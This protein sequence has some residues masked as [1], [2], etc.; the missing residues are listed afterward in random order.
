MDTETPNRFAP[1]MVRLVAAWLLIGAFFKLLVGTPNDLPQVV[2][3]LPMELGLTYSLVI[4]IELAL[5]FCALVKPA[6]A[7]FLLSGALVVFDVILTT[8]LGSDN[9]GCFGSKITMPPWLMLTI[10]S[11][12]LVGLLLSKP[13]RN[14]PRA[15]PVPVAVLVMAIGFAIPWMMDRQV[16]TGITADGDPVDK[17]GRAWL[18]MNIEDWVGQDVRE[19]PLS[20]PPLSDHI[21]VESIITDGIWV[22]WRQDCD[23]CK[24]HL[25][26]M[27]NTEIGERMV[28]LVQLRM[29]TD[30][31]ANRVVSMMPSGGFVQMLT[32]PESMDYV[33]TTPG[34]MLVENEKIVGAK[35]GV[36]AEESF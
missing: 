4:S 10:D 35:E 29:P 17:P 26:N 14:M 36:S 3:D 21:D 20:K 31:E 5:G 34:E 8:Q 7:W 16:G 15:A 18:E 24:E 22:F 28:T 30:T 11:V 9:C 6:W 19:S 23:H 33:I 1:W 25:A 13:W 12:L 32:L 2:R 27:V